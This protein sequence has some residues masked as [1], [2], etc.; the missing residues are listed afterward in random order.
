MVEKRV[1]AAKSALL[2]IEIGSSTSDGAIAM[3]GKF[4]VYTL[5]SVYVIFLISLGLQSWAILLRIKISLSLFIV[6]FL[7]L[8]SLLC[9]IAALNTFSLRL[10][11]SS[12]RVFVVR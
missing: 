11:V 3:C 1:R 5:R 10:S 6:K 4:S 12:S 2:L 8:F 9:G 7:N